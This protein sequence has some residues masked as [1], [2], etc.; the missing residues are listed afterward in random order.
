MLK[1]GSGFVLKEQW[2]IALVFISLLLKTFIA[3]AR[4]VYAQIASFGMCSVAVLFTNA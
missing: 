3:L 1:K 4:E 2:L